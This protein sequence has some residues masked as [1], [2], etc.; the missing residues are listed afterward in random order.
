M[1]LAIIY[2]PTTHVLTDLAYKPTTRCTSDSAASYV[3]LCS[4]MKGIVMA[5]VRC[6]AAICADRLE[7]L[8]STKTCVKC[9]E[10]RKVVGFMVA[11]HKTGSFLVMVDAGDRETLRLAVRANRRAR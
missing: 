11:P 5:C 1:S 10:T 8:P 9:S 7:A 3:L 6:G 4:F 2:L